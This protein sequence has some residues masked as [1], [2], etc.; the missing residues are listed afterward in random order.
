MSQGQL[1]YDK[2]GQADTQTDGRTDKRRTKWSLCTAM[3]RR[4][5][6]TD[7]VGMS[8]RGRA[9]ML[10][11]GKNL[12]RGKAG[13]RERG[14]AAAGML[15]FKLFLTFFLSP[16]FFL[17]FFL[18]HFFFHFFFWS[19]FFFFLHFFS[20]F[21]LHYFFYVRFFFLGGGRGRGGGIDF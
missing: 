5:H 13:I 19:F 14:R 21:F 6:K 10:E 2:R 4:R 16:R 12:E 20:Q 17:P 15:F 18:L 3:L 9:G 1:F 8:E 7:K 11:R